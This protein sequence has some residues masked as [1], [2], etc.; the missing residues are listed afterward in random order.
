[1]EPVVRA[2]RDHLGVGGMHRQCI[3]LGAQATR[4]SALPLEA[5]GE[6][7]VDAGLLGIVERSVTVKVTPRGVAGAEWE[8]AV[9]LD[10]HSAKLDDDLVRTAVLRVDGRESRPVRWTGAK[11]GGH[12]REGVLTFA[13][14]GRAVG[15][16]ELLILRTGE[17]APRVFSW[18]A[19]SLR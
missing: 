17:P 4:L 5:V 7:V 15:P 10:T 19:I 6:R 16:V 2:G 8:F 12:Q 18:D 9:V 11:P 14:P 1:V 13:S 3:D